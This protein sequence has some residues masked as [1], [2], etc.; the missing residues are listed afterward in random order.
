MTADGV[1]PMGAGRWGADERWRSPLLTS[2]S[3]SRDPQADPSDLISPRRLYDHGVQMLESPSLAALVEPLVAKVNPAELE[4]RN[5]APGSVV[6]LAS[7]G[8]TAGSD[9][10][11]IEIELVGDPGVPSGVIEVSA[12]VRSGGA[13][14]AASDGTSGAARLTRRARW[15]S[16]CGWSRCEPLVDAPGSSR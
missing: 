3:S 2:R 13:G 1:Q 10:R 16:T 14:A 4:A 6:R 8:S 9:G 7:N 11:S 15:S 5:I 12:N